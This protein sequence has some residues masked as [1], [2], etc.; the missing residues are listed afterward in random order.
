MDKAKVTKIKMLE[1]E[2]VDL[3]EA[4]KQR[5]RPGKKPPMGL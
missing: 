5:K 3:Q 4:K 1:R 2:K